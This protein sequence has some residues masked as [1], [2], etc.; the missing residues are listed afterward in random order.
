MIH[1]ALTDSDGLNLT[2]KELLFYQQ[3]TKP[4]SQLGLAKNAMAGPYRSTIKGRGMEFD[5]VRQYQAGDDV[6][7]IDWRVTARTGS[8]HTKIFKEEKERPVLMLVD[9]SDSMIFGSQL[10]L[11]SVQAAHLGAYLAWQ[12]KQRGDR[13]GGVIFNQS[14]HQELRPKGRASGVLQWLHQLKQLYTNQPQALLQ[15]EQGQEPVSLNQ[16]DY[17]T[18]QLTRLRR[19]AQ[20]GSQVH[21]IS[22]FAHLDEA[23]EKQLA[24]IK[25]HN[26]VTAW[27]IF[28]PLEQALPKTKGLGARLSFNVITE[29]GA[30]WLRLGKDNQNYQQQA[31]LRQQHL[32]ARLTRR[33]IGLRQIS[34][35]Q[36]L[37][38]QV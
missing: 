31:Q 24:L 11:K 14:Q 38:G 15:L 32:L 3:Q 2:L 16:A 28:D 36:P 13:I 29:R 1:S 8:T 22:D 27:Q 35:G 30:G 6:R 23:G 9:L 10:L 26:Q 33:A 34:A 20:P 4:R 18:Q 21:V 5:E 37:L 19:L 17:F 7:A 25:R 12:A